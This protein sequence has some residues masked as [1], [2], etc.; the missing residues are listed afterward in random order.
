MDR[1]AARPHSLDMT[2]GR[3]ISRRLLLRRGAQLAGGAALLGAAPSLL[4]ACSSSKSPSTTA[5]TAASGAALAK[6]SLQLN[7]LENAQFAGSFYA[8]TKGYYKDAGVDVTLLPGGPNLSPEPIVVAGTALVAISHT[9][10]IIQAINNGADLKLIGAGFQKN[11]TC[12]VSRAD[13][14]IKTPQEMV[15]KKIGISA[16]NTPI[17]DSFLKA[18]NMTAAGIDVVTVQFDPSSL[19]TGEIDGLMGFAVNEPIVLKLAGTPTYYFLL[20]DFNYP[21]ME[22]MYIATGANLANPAKRKLIDGIMS[23]ESRGWSDVITDPDG[24]ATLAVTDFGKDLNLNATQQKLQTEGEGAFVADADT[25][26]H[27]LFWM[28]DEKIAGTIHSLGLGGVTATTSM[29]TDEVLSDIYKGG[30]TVA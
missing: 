10:E 30:S 27:G 7:Y 25:M 11:P 21:L 9:A 19:A 13:A 17:W 16:T 2:S 3:P 4:A 8:E 26:A 24:A 18:N 28:T 15:G 5:T 6:V 23:G 1:N 22:D 20:N 29:F 12:I 14:P